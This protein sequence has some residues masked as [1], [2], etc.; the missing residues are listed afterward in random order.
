MVRHRV[1]IPAC[2]GSNPSTV[3]KKGGDR[4]FLKVCDSGSQ[5]NGYAIGNENEVLLLEAGCSFKDI[6]QMLDFRV[7]NIVGM[8]VSHEHG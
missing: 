2:G 1:L 6:K 3:D 8:C 7:D 5:A 4:M